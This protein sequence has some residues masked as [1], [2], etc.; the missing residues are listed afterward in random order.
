MYQT[1]VRALTTKDC[2]LSA[3][4]GTLL[5]KP[6]KGTVFLVLIE[7]SK[8]MTKQVLLSVDKELVVKSILPF[9]SQFDGQSASGDLK[10]MCSGKRN[11]GK[12]RWDDRSQYIYKH[13]ER[14]THRV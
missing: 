11:S 7:L 12:D 4:R 5:K 1:K 9:D 13:R 10:D 8:E 2:E 14:E 3:R 6:S